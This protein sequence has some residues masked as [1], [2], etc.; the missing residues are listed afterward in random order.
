HQGRHMLGEHFPLHRAIDA[1][2]K[3]AFTGEGDRGVA[4]MS[5]LRSA[6]GRLKD[7]YFDLDNLE[8]LGVDVINPRL[9]H[10]RQIAFLLGPFF[11]EEPLAFRAQQTSHDAD[12][13]GRDFGGFDKIALV[14]M[15]VKPISAGG[16]DVTLD[17][18]FAVLRKL[19]L[20]RAWL[21]A[22]SGHDADLPRRDD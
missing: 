6:E 7:P 17:S 9:Q 3:T 1:D 8:F 14:A 12:E 18:L 5:R 21:P 15:L 11:R 2:R 4:V 20:T 22:K 13:A 10:L 19:A 16:Q